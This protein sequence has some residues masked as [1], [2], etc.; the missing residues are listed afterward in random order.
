MSELGIVIDFNDEII[1]WDHVA[2]TMRDYFTDCPSPKPTKK[3][4]RTMLL[5]SE[6]LEVAG[7][8]FNSET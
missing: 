4:I 6:E 3:E 7:K 8:S 5:R 2:I 1:S